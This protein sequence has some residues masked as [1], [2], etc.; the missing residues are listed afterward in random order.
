MAP[1][2]RSHQAANPPR[3]SDVR[4]RKR[5]G[6]DSSG[7][8]GSSN[9]D[10]A[11]GG[12]STLQLGGEAGSNSRPTK[13]PMTT[14]TGRTRQLGEFFSVIYM[15]WGG[16]GLY[17]TSIVLLVSDLQFNL[18]I[19]QIWGDFCSIEGIHSK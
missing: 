5:Q 15:G 6:G 19:F 12:S 4:K 2:S 16:E 14:G 11:N 8:S 7:G 1:G 10:P 3:D 18:F 17:S 13:T 9:P